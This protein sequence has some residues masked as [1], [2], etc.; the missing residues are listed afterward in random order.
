MKDIFPDFKSLIVQWRKKKKK[1]N[2]QTLKYNIVSALTKLS[3]ATMGSH[4]KVPTPLE[5]LKYS[6][7]SITS[8]KG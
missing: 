7:H 5:V 3:T 2:D 1:T 6:L 8:T 4:V